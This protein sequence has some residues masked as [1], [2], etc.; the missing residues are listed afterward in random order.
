MRR[1]LLALAA[2]AA[3][4]AIARAEDPVEF[5]RHVRPILADACFKC[6]GLDPKARR[7]K[8]RLDLPEDAYKERLGGFPIKPGDLKEST[9]WD[10][11]TSD[12]PDYVMPPP[13]ANKKLTAAQKEV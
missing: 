2:L 12:D 13:A 11:I 1:H 5:N 9:A 8:L 7:A 3:A 4:P 10:R 6:H